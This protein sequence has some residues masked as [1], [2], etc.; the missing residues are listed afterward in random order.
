MQD[1]EERRV[2]GPDDP[3]AV[4]VR[5]RRAA[6]AGDRVDALDVLAAE[7]VEHLADQA[8]ALVLAYAR[9]QERVQL[10]VRGVDHRAG[11]GEQRDLVDGLDPAGL[12]EHLLAVDDRQCPPPAAPPGSAS[13]SGRRRSARR[14]ARARA[15][16][17][18]PCGP[19]PGRCRRPDGTRRAAWRSRRGRRI[20]RLSPLRRSRGRRARGRSR[21]TGCRAGDAS[22][23]SRSPRSPA[24]RR[25]AA[26][27]TGSACPSPRCR[28]GSPSCSGCW[29]SRRS[30]AHPSSE[31]SRCCL[32]R[33]SRSVRS[34]SRSIRAPSRLR[35][36][37]TCG[38]PW[39]N[40]TS[41]MVFNINYACSVGLT[42]YG[43]GARAA[44][45][46]G[47]CIVEPR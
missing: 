8:D 28:C 26:A 24:R 43:Q 37:R 15:A 41:S 18:R 38:S 23:P 31:A 44:R 10:V 34:R 19:P 30:A 21:A 29:R 14:S 47:W 33:C 27:R 40:P 42:R 4:D 22:R 25:A 39:L 13:R 12:Q 46:A 5:M 20:A 32:R 6:L 9:A 45:V 11:L 3:V 16:R 7:V 35:S 36:A 2:A 17:S 1:V